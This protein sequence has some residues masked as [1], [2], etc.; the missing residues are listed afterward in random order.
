MVLT[1]AVLGAVKARRDGD[2]LSV[3]A[4]KTTELRLGSRSMRAPACAW[5]SCRAG[6]HSATTGTPSRR[7]WPSPGPTRTTWSP[8]WLSTGSPGW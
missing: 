7:S 2:R 6:V 3:P 5:T 8:S 4:G 1:V